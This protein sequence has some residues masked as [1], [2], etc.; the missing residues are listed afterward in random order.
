[1]VDGRIG[2]TK[3]LDVTGS[4]YREEYMN[5]QAKRDVATAS[6]EF[7]NNNT[8]MR[9]GVTHADDT[10]QQGQE[11]TSTLLQLGA[12]QRLLDGK[13]DVTADSDF[14]ISGSGSDSESVDFP[15]R[16]RVGASY[17]IRPDVRLVAR[18][19]I[20][21]GEDFNSATTQFGIDAAPWAGARLATTLN[22]QDMNENGKRSFANLGLTQSLL[23]GKNWGVDV[24]VDSNQTFSGGIDSD[25][26]LNPAHPVASGGYL[27]RS[28]LT[29]DFIAISTGAT[30]RTDLWSW[31]GRVE[32]RDADSGNQYGIQSS[33]L[34]Q[35]ENGVSLSLSARAFRYDQEDASRTTAA[36]VEGSVAWRPLGSR[37]S[38]LDK[39]EVRMDKVE[40]GVAGGYN[41]FGNSGLTVSGDAKSWRIVNNFAL[42]R[43]S[44]AW[45]DNDSL[46]QRSQFTLYYGSKYVFSQ[47]DQQDFKGYTHLLGIEA[48]LDLTTWLDLGVAGSIRH[49]VEAN[50]FAFAVGPT[51]GVTP[52]ANAW[53]SVGYNILGF[54][55]RDFEESRY[56]R[57]GFYIM[58]RLKFDQQT[59]QDL[60]LTGGKE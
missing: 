58:M 28:R 12:S 53:I 48:R 6:V 39:L 3:G 23:L 11:A 41:P 14:S 22:Q 30:Y 31:N 51:I 56:T 42:N 27:N 29:D 21:D 52:F 10:T 45:G 35:I 55:D 5:S 34:R 46:E 33:V 37:W 2:S 26:V 13:L 54:R 15:T 4:A 16:Y 18:H 49:S 17:A 44:G 40:D 59:T 25:K 1:G 38:I 57:D 7:R 8:S 24:S 32:Y 43:V 20:T 9:A 47:F 60:G 50:N 36:N 19:E